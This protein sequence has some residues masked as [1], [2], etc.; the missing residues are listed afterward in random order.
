MACAARVDGWWWLLLMGVG[1]SFV[2]PQVGAV[3]AV[4][5]FDAG[6]GSPSGPGPGHY[7]RS[8]NQTG[9]T[10]ICEAHPESTCND[11]EATHC[12]A[13]RSACY[14]DPT[15]ACADLTLDECLEAAEANAS[16]DQPA[17]TSHCWNS[18]SA[19]GT[20]ERAR[21]NCQRAWCQSEC[22]IP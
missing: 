4:C 11:C 6:G 16:E 17:S 15:C 12:C 13:T 5:G 1:C 22:E 8:T 20:V 19:S 14:G 9:M 7:Q 18:F 21:V 10:P 2:D 3:Q